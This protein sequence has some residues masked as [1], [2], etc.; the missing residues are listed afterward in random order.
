M[1]EK[2]D[3]ALEAYKNINNLYPENAE[4]DYGM[5]R[6]YIFHKKDLTKGLDYICK[7]YNKYVS[8]NSPYRVDAEKIMGVVYQELKK[9]DQLHIF[10]EVLEKNNINME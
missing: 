3:E 8:T 6:I 10:K 7:A 5:G 1:Q 4:A 2:Y 9:N